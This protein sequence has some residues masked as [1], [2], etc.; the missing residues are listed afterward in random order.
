[1]SGHAFIPD[2]PRLPTLDGERLRLRPLDDADVP[3]LY[4]VFGDPEVARFWA[5]PALAHEAAAAG[6]VAQARDNFAARR[7][8][9][10]GVAL[11]ADD[12][13]IGTCSLF[14]LD[15]AHRRA[16]VGYALARSHWRR[17]YASEALALAIA[18]GFTVLGLRRL[19]ADV[20][21]RNDAS[22]RMLERFGFLREGYLR[23]RFEVAGEVQDSVVLGFLAS[24][25]RA[26]SPS[27]RS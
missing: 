9:R 17:G 3:A 7:G 23:E 1:M 24:E 16:E 22:L 20:D 11:R 21:P 15:A 14:N 12:V 5:V 8:F 4:T 6:I 13:V 27:S 18:F 2:A 19:E 10:W 25:W 26:A